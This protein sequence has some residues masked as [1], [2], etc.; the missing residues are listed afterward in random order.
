MMHLHTEILYFLIILL[1]NQE[2]K[3]VKNECIKINLKT[4]TFDRFT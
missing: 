3:N 1:L 4:Y 2:V